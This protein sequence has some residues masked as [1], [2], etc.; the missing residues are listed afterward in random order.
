MDFAYEPDRAPCAFDGCINR[1]ESARGWCHGHYRQW[2]HG[3]ELRPLR[4][5]VRARGL[6][7]SFDGCH[8]PQQAKGLC[9]THYMQRLRGDDLYPVGTR[10]RPRAEI[11]LAEHCAGP[12]CMRPPEKRGLCGG[13]YA[14]QRQ[15]QELRPL[16]RLQP[17]SFPECGRRAVANGL[18][19]AHDQQRRSGKALKPV[20][21][22]HM[23]SRL[24]SEGYLLVYA[25]D[26]PNARKSGYILQHI[27]V[28]TEYLGRPLVPG[29]EVHHRNG[30]RS[31]N[32]RTNL[33]LWST[34]QPA[35]QRVLDKLAWAQEIIALYGQNRELYEVV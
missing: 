17:C 6:V 14:Q 3:K 31:D 4:A 21:V 22:G 23:K 16:R 11:N 2:L 13:H 24:T 33:E 30:D 25:P 15:G 19:S 35:G 10:Q 29:E 9:G 18:C 5:K 20:R 34:S 1:A 28:M 26:H 12:D 8:R 7:C 27:V 32:R